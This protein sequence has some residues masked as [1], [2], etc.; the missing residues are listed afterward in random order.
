MA[1]IR[2]KKLAQKI[3]ETAISGEK[4]TA[5]QML[6]NVGYAKSV[7]KHK[8]SEIIEGAGVQTSLKELGFDEESAKRV[9]TEILEH[10]EDDNVRLGAAK[11]IFKVFGSYAAEKSFNVTATASVDELKE[12]IQHS[13]AK[14][15][16]HNWRTCVLPK[17]P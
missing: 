6:E 2:Q 13:L 11:E 4:I 16:P 15:R 3:V 9:V 8:P 7:A 5:G 10:G 1:T 12:V 17:A 14:F